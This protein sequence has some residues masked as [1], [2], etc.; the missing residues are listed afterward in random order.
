MKSMKRLLSYILAV[1][2]ALLFCTPAFAQTRGNGMTVSITG[3]VTDSNHAPIPGAV[4]VARGTPTG[5]LTAED[6]TYSITA[7]KGQVLEFSVLGYATEEVIVDT[8]TRID[9]ILKEDAELLQEAIVE[10][11]YGERRLVDVT[12]TVSRVN[13]EDMVKAPVVTFD[14]AMQ[15]RIAGVNITSADGQPGQGMDIVIRGANSLT[16]SNS[17][18]YIIDGFPMED[19]SASAVSANDIAS[20]TVLKDASSTAIYGSRAANGVI[21]IETKKG[22]LG[23]PTVTYNGT[24]GIQQV[25]KTM[26]LMD[27]YEFVSYQLERSNTS[28]TYNYYLTDRG[29]TLEDYKNV[30]PVNWQ[31]KVFR[32]API[33]MHNLSMM[34][35]NG[36]TRYSASGS[37]VNQEGVII[38]SGYQ[39]YSGR[40]ALE[41]KL[42]KNLT[43]GLNVSYSED[44]TYGQTS[45]AQLSDNSAYTTH[46]MYRTWAYKPI[47]MDSQNLDDL[48]DDDIEAMGIGNTVMNP[49]VSN[50]NEQISNKK[51]MFNGNGFLKWNIQEGLTMQV[52]GGYSKYI[53]RQEN[54]YNSK[55]YQGYSSV[56]N[57]KDVNALFRET[58]NTSWL[59][60]NTLTWNKTVE[61][62]HKFELMG[63]FTMEGAK[64]SIYG[65]TTIQIPNEALGLSGMDDGLPESTTVTSGWL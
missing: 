33:R 14:Q 10:V 3:R 59:E 65:F 11:G 47:L 32:T 39:K 60:E 52:R 16:Q 64:S 58:I 23:S 57:S 27:P 34:G 18:L 44:K 55:T 63:G 15:G 1:P 36:E 50:S 19:F 31:E 54:F 7:K 40:M 28:S 4:V 56:N 43:L 29:M 22:K 53:K 9:V 8:Q 51:I 6:G 17:P 37:I 13:V 42:R 2:L 21:I 38:N 5:A 41:Q 12:G 25:T 35:G 49:Y 26:D 48:F 20:I 62:K 45:S 61:D 46:L 30:E 24:F